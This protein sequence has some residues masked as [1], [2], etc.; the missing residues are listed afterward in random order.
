[1]RSGEA[2]THKASRGSLLGFRECRTRTDY[3]EFLSGYFPWV[4]Q[5]KLPIRKLRI[6]KRAL[7]LKLNRIT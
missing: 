6:M 3:E 1:M 4:Y 7:V 2:V 5:Q